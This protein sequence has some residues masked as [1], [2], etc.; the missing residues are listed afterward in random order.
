MMRATLIL[1][2]VC[3]ATAG[4]LAPIEA[5]AKVR[6]GDG[7]R[8][9]AEE[10][11][12]N[13]FGRQSCAD[14][15]FD[16]GDLSC[17]HS[18]TVDT[19]RCVNDDPCG[20]GAIDRGESCDG[21]NFGDRSCA[22]YG[23]DAGALGCSD[24]CDAIDTSGCYNEQPP[25]ECG[26]GAV[27]PGEECDGND[28]GGKTCGDYGHV[29]GTLKCNPDCSYDTSDCNSCGDGRVQ[30]GESCDGADLM[31]ATCRSEGF[32]GGQL[33]CNDACALDV[34]QCDGGA[35]ACGDGRRDRGESCDGRD[36]G[37]ESCHSLGLGDGHLGC[38]DSC[39]F[40]ASDCTEGGSCGDGF[41]DADEQCDGTDTGEFTCAY[42]GYRGGRIACND[43]CRL[44]TSGCNNDEIVPNDDCGNGVI[45]P[46][47]ECDGTNIG[48]AYCCGH[49]GDRPI[50]AADCRLNFDMCV[51]GQDDEHWN[52]GQGALEDGGGSGQVPD[53]P[54]T[55][56]QA[57]PTTTHWL[58]VLLRR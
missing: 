49:H 45:E 25:P 34:S 3:V 56:S 20:N 52:E 12:G 36:L 18:C 43:S 1:S 30:P 4:V 54:A 51:H 23:F 17:T 2:F 42:F 46:G 55:C 22:D 8:G 38:N 50:C 19:S 13:D 32:D 44:D 48:G 35:P 40:D 24:T 10:C 6:C 21:D 57:G 9:G 33:G 47:E 41:V 29:G 26:D 14:F 31:G 58:R 39:S 53:V 27:D 5:D 11:D 28:L 15:G 7:N 16:R 37:G